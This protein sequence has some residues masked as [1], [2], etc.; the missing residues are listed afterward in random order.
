MAFYMPT[1]TTT[2][3]FLKS[4]KKYLLPGNTL[5]KIMLIFV[6]NRIYLLKIG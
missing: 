4:C 3:Y 6:K 1:A 2:G 5:H